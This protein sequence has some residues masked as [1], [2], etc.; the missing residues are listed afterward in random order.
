[1][2]MILSKFSKQSSSGRNDSIRHVASTQIDA[3]NDWTLR[4]NILESDILIRVIMHDERVGDR[5]ERFVTSYRD[6]KCN[7]FVNQEEQSPTVVLRSTARLCT[8]IDVRLISELE[9]R[10]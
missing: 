7:E 2:L 10:Q 3:R 5:F 1:M 6:A 4:A 8:A 9:P